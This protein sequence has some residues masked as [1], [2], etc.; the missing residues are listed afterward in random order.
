MVGPNCFPKMF[1][2]WNE[3]ESNPLFEDLQLSL[4][5]LVSL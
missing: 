1:S 2:D 4:D 5:F 3:E